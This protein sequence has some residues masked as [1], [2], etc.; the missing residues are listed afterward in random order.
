FKMLRCRAITLAL[1]LIAFAACSR[2]PSPEPTPTPPS[3]GAGTAAEAQQEPQPLSPEELAPVIREVAETEGGAAKIVIE[4]ARPVITA[5]QVGKSFDGTELRIEPPVDG[6]LRFT[7]P[8]TL[9]FEPREGFRPGTRYE[10]ELTALETP[11]GI[12]TTPQAGRWTRVFTTPNFDFERFSLAS[13]DYPRKRA[14]MHLVFSGAVD[15][16]QVE[17][18]A[19]ITVIGAD[20]R[21]RRGAQFRFRQG[22]QPHTVMAQLAS[23]ALEGGGRLDLTLDQGVPSAIDGQ[24]LAGKHTAS[25]ELSVGPVAKVLSNYRAEGANGF[26]VQVI[27][28]DSSVKSRRYYWDREQHSYYEVSTRCELDEADA[29]FGIHFEPEV[30]FSVSPAAGGFRIFGD[31][32]RGGYHMRI[33]AGVRTA[34]GGMLHQAYESDFTV[35]ARSPQ[36]RFV[37]KG[38]YLPRTAWASLPIRHLNLSGATLS[39][40]HVPAENLVFWMSDDTNEAAS[41]RTSNLILKKQI[42][43]QSSADVETTTYVDLASLVPPTTKGLIEL[44]LDAGSTHDT[45]R[46]LLTDVHLVAKR[47]A[48]GSERREVRAWALDMDSLDPV[49]GAEIR[50]IRKSGYVLSSCSTGRDGGCTLRPAAN[51]VDPSAPFALIAQAGDDLTYLKFNELK[52]EVQEEQIAGA[53]YLDDAKYRA[54]IYSDRGV[55]RPGETAHLAAIVRQGDHLAPPADMP[56]VAKLADPRGKTLKRTT[57]KTNAAG[58]LDLDLDF[59]AFAATGRYEAKLEVAE[60]VIGQYRFQVEEF[61]PER[62]KVDVGAGRP[63]YLF[64]EPMEVTVGARYLFGGVP[65]K[66]RVEVSCEIA[67]AN[68][69]PKDNANFHYGV[70]RPESSPQRPLALGAVTAELDDE[71]AGTYSCPGAGRAGGFRGP[72]QL[73]ARAA[74]FESGSGRTTVNQAS[75]PVHPERFYLGLQSGTTK[76]ESG[77]DLVVEGVVVDWQGTLSSDTETVV[78]SLIRLESEY[79]WYYDEARGYE[80]YRR[81][82]RPVTAESTEVPVVDGKFRLSWKPTQD[83][84]G[85]LVRAEAGGARTD[86]KLEGRGDWYY[87]APDETEVDQTPRPGR[88]AWI[89]LETPD[90]ARVGERIP[91]RFK[92]PY[93]G[94]VLLTAETDRLLRSE[95]MEVEPGEAVWNLELDEFTPNVYVTAFLVKDPHLDSAQAFLPDRAFGV[96]SLG[97]EPTAFTH[98]LELTAPEEIRSSS[99]LTVSLDLGRAEGP[100]YATVAAVDEGILSLTRFQSP[101]PF[102]DIFA[103]RALG[104]ET[105]ETVGWT[106]LVPPSGPSSTV[107]GDG[108]GGPGRVQPVKPVALWSGLVEVPKSGKVDVTFDVPQYRGELRVMAVTAGSRKMG[109]ADASV[110]VRDPLVIQATL[111]RF[112]T[113]DDE[114]RLPVHVTNLSGERREIEV[115]LETKAMGIGGLTPSETGSSPVEI[116]GPDRRTL[117]LDHGA[118]EVVLFRARA[119][120][121]SGAARL[122]V[123]AASGDLS[124]SEETE[125]PLLPAGPKSRATQRIELAAGTTDLTPYLAGWVPMS[126]RSTLWVTNNPYGDTFSHLKHLLRYPYGCIEQTTSTTRPLL[127]L[128]ELIGQVDPALLA[129]K[130][131]EGMATHGINRLLAMQTPD[132]GFAYWPGGTRPTFWG[133]AY[134]THLLLDAQ[135]L[136]YPVAQDRIDEAI[137]WMDRQI[138]HHFEAGQH[139]GNH[140]SRNAEPYFHFVL[141]KAGKPHK[142]R[143]EKL[144]GEL[145]SK[146]QHEQREHRFMLQA[147]LYEAGD[148]RYE[149][150]LKSPDLS[151]LTNTRRN[152]WSF[153]SD[154]RMRGFMLSTFVDLFGRD[155]A[156]EP[157][158][159]L[160]AEGLRGHK[161]TWYTTQELVWGITGLGK[162]AAAGADRF[163]P[164]TL[165]GNGRRLEP[166]DSSQ[167]SERTWNLAR[168]SEYDSLDLEVGQKSEG[169][170]YLILASEGVRTVPDWRTGGDG[171][172]LA[173]RYVDAAGKP[174]DPAR[175][176]TLGDLVYVELTLRNTTNEPIANI[177]LVDR[178]PAGWEIENPRLGRDATAGWLDAD[179]LWQ[180]DHMDLRDDRIELFGHLAR[181]ESRKVVYAARAV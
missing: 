83:A 170:L 78:A 100:T 59:P 70:W 73:I 181:G 61:V 24:Q 77:S 57:L 165:E 126:E 85:F 32:E 154:R 149:L 27:C 98:N 79:G 131:V 119:R 11:A 76:V 71:G 29:A 125:V 128:A 124:S 162:F 127:Y 44:R 28:D 80:T 105:F 23:D 141:A 117:T 39:V 172:L 111:P 2:D 92:A 43:L 75:V 110:T 47:A 150:E 58:Y 38:R 122:A 35:P 49:R 167:G 164:P 168:A 134:A 41:E 34:D 151:V 74:V 137:D 99:P 176:L 104:V 30:D 179:K 31:F 163:D 103:R 69:R 81:Y 18:R 5:E 97:I 161:S 15:V 106:F 66:H 54:S 93:R 90:V 88:P 120:Q 13:V 94:R 145:P 129:D 19:R 140:Y 142:A 25:L 14:E 17:Q 36:I 101:D 136:D 118:A 22:E 8:S 7:S 139:R 180:P 178:I 153:Y 86:L 72:A 53:P 123:T 60:Q 40:R 84:V 174:I 51:D 82:L 147:A 155:A 56:V 12:L 116:L 157:L 143:A 33:E 144:L 177:A 146:P 10:V 113:R 37:S 55:Y 20:G 64:G 96:R 42:A 107:G 65:S 50:L 68:F 87:W 169:K 95:W 63:D 114:I 173:R 159:D 9:T 135:T 166:E 158:A 109:R 21:S 89:A 121:S 160:V 156:G 115:T 6:A 102:A 108:A 132:G 16:R 148:Q 62:M 112:L 91:V 48:T 26:Y 1:T 171:L 67:P 4:L 152:G 138:S 3:P 46:I 130:D 52:A 45:A 133:T 175:G